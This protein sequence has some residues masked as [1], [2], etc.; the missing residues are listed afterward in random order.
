[1]E[2]LSAPAGVLVARRGDVTVLTNTGASAA[3]V[4]VPLGGRLLLDSGIGRE[5]R[6]FTAG[7]A[8]LPPNTT[9]WVGR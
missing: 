1:M 5:R 9:W 8:A 6:R 4:P 3:S 2:W 7:V